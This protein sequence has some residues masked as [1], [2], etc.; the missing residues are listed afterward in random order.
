MEYKDL[1]FDQQIEAKLTI[2]LSTE[3][4]IEWLKSN[5]LKKKPSVFGDESNK[6]KDFVNSH[7]AK[8]DEPNLSLAVARYGTHIE[9]LK[10]LY[11][12]DDPFIKMAIL[13]NPLVGPK[14]FSFNIGVLDESAAEKLIFD[15][16]T[17]AQQLDALFTNPYIDRAFLVKVVNREGKF[18]DLSEDGIFLSI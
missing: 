7:Y 9:T 5:A 16:K 15:P 8:R 17:T 12:S 11:R 4:A 1:T 18:K 10:K 6:L 14:E 13:A 3:S 2:S